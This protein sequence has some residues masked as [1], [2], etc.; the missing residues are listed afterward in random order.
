MKI[1]EFS[2]SKKFGPY[3]NG[4]EHNFKIPPPPPFEK[5]GRRG[6]FCQ[7]GRGGI[8]IVILFFEFSF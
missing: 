7:K 6:D 2:E 8:L 4:L 1:P 5:G 3:P